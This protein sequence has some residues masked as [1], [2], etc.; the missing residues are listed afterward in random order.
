METLDNSFLQA[1]KD[2]RLR[3][4]QLE[5]LTV[6]LQS[7]MV[8][9]GIKANQV[10]TQLEFDNLKEFIIRNYPTITLSEIKLAFDCALSGKLNLDSSE[11]SCYGDFT[12]IYFGRIINAYIKWANS[13]YA[14]VEQ[15]KSEI[16]ELPAPPTDWTDTYER[17]LQSAKDGTL[18]KEVIPQ[19][20]YKWLIKNKGYVL[21]EIE[22]DEFREKA[23]VAI[24]STITGRISDN[25]A[26]REDR[27]VIKTLELPINKFHPYWTKINVYAIR[28]AIIQFIQTE[29]L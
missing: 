12:A 14:E 26:S 20:L 3:D 19:P 24:R 8:I 11:I 16:K 18:H 4:C 13:K 1:L 25:T 9:C 10:P 29:S 22:K 5:E 2:K 28:L 23:V 21:T 15:Q 27:A 7:V 6:T 17:L